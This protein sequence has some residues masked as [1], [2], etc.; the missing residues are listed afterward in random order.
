M[1]RNLWII[2]VL[3]CLPLA[4]WGARLRLFEVETE[5]HFLFDVMVESNMAMSN[6]LN[7]AYD[8]C[9]MLRVGGTEARW[10]SASIILGGRGIQTPRI[11]VGTFKVSRQVFVPTKGDWARIYDLIV[12]TT[13]KAQ[14]AEVEIFGNL[15]SDNSTQLTG[16]S[17]G[18]MSLEASD[19]WFATDDY[20]DGSGDPSLAHVFRRAAGKLRPT[21]VT[22]EQ[23]NISVRYQ[24]KL[25]PRGR[26]AIVFFAVQTKTGTEARALAESLTKF[27]TDA[28]TN[29]DAQD[30]GLIAN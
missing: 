18:D 5:G 30:I 25:P 4:A 28:R 10:E 11:D 1:S 8:G 21:T 16:T 6:G 17:D 20:S 15:G 3:T 2:V 29:L 24:I 19:T 26:K 13:T 12:N 23:D 22:L 14:T 9:Y 7:D 27:G